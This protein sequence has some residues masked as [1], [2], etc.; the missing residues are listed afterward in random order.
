VAVHGFGVDAAR[1]ADTTQVTEQ[2]L[3][4]RADFTGVVVRLFEAQTFEG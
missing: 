1:A 3:P 4:A 2:P